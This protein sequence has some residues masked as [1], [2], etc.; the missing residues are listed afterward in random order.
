MSKR[1]L[2]CAW[3]LSI[4]TNTISNSVPSFLSL[5]YVLE[6]CGVNVQHGG[7]LRARTQAAM[8]RGD[9][10][11][12]KHACWCCYHRQHTADQQQQPAWHTAQLC[13][14]THQCAEK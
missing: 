1:T 11:A 9:A 8:T 13:A 4:D 7:H 3:F 10:A 12:D 14:A 6:S 2:N 5:V